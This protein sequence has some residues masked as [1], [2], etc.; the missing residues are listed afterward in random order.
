MWDLL[1]EFTWNVIESDLN[2]QVDILH[3]MWKS[4][5]SCVITKFNW[6]KLC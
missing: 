6:M 1:D 4:S 2:T 5:L 3:E